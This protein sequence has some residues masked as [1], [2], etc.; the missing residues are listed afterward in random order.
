MN[1][2]IKN[3]LIDKFTCGVCYEL[4]PLLMNFRCD[5]EKIY[6]TPC[7]YKWNKNTCPYCKT[8]SKPKFINSCDA[9]LANLLFNINDNIYQCNNNCSFKSNN[10]NKHIEHYKLC[11]NKLCNKKINNYNEDINNDIREE[12]N[13]LLN[14]L[15]STSNVVYSN[16]FY[17]FNYS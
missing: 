1:E 7:L 4:H 3:K 8:G 9:E 15:E 16:R 5:C 10:V 13:S 14:N 6:C 12:I 11:N 2:D 17:T